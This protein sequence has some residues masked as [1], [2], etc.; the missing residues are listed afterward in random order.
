MNRT[1]YT[2]TLWK[3]LKTAINDIVF[4]SYT[5]FGDAK[6]RHAVEEAWPRG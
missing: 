2:R 1:G 3:K 4:S 6:K 5:K